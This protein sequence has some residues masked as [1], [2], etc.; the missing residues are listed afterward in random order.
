MLHDLLND[1]GQDSAVRYSR[2]GEHAAAEA[3]SQ[4]KEQLK[5]AVQSRRRS[6]SVIG[7]PRSIST[8]PCAMTPTRTKL[9]VKI[10]LMSRKPQVQRNRTPTRV[11]IDLQ[12]LSLSSCRSAAGRSRSVRRV[13]ENRQTPQTVLTRAG[14]GQSRHRRDSQP[15]APVAERAPLVPKVLSPPASNLPKAHWWGSQQTALRSPGVKTPHYFPETEDTVYPL[16]LTAEEQSLASCTY[17]QP[18]IQPTLKSPL[19]ELEAE[20]PPRPTSATSV[21]DYESD[22]VPR[23]ESP[24]LDLEERY[25]KLSDF[26]SELA[27]KTDCV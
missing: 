7:A 15:R 10:D 12:N 27:R 14:R 1:L 18:L 3:F 19:P 4:R 8:A 13:G 20:D 16:N 23:C 24:E 9:V 25:S 11:V 17:I 26:L 5:Q 22:D 2:L 6:S 21:P